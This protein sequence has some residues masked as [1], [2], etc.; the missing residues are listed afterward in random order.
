[1]LTWS[2]VNAPIASYEELEP[3]EEN[4]AQEKQEQRQDKQKESA[5]RMKQGV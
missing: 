4:V 5:E 2:V 1:M 3:V